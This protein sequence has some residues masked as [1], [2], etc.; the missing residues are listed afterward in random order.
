MDL[1]LRVSSPLMVQI[2][3]ESLG[4]GRQMTTWVEDKDLI[5]Q[6]NEVKL[7]GEDAWFKIVKVYDDIKVPK[8]QL[9]VRGFKNNI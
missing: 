9:G 7:D 8:S 4:T 3:I 5:R 2:D 6:D 1:R